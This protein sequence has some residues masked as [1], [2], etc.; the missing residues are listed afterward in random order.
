MAPAGA[1]A[2]LPSTTVNAW[3]HASATPLRETEPPA[4]HPFGTIE[5]R[6]VSARVFALGEATHG[7]HESFELKRRLT[8]HMVR[9]HGYRLVAYEASASS[10]RGGDDYIAGRTN[11]RLKAIGS[12]GMLVWAIDEN[13]ELLDDLRAWNSSHAASQRVRLI[14]VDAQDGRAVVAR[15][16]ALL[17]PASASLAQRAQVLVGRAPAATQRMYGG[18]R[19]AFDTVQTE[20]A[21]LATELRAAPLAD[22][23]DGAEREL[24]IQELVGHL[25][26]Y[27]S[28]GGRDRLMASLL[29]TQLAGVPAD[30]RCIV[31]AHN[32]HVK[33]S[34]LRYLGSDELAMG[35]HLA[36]A[37]GDGYYALGFAFGEGEFQ[38]NAL[39]PDGTWGFKRYT[40]S[41]P[42]RTS[43]EEE[44]MLA[45]L[46][47][48]V[49]DLRGAGAD[50]TLRAW[51]DTGHGQ[52][53]W[54]GYNV[55]DD[56]DAQTRDASRLMRTTPSED[57][58]GFA[59]L[60]RT[61]AA[62]PVDTSLIIARS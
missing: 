54:G 45:G 23:L 47:D 56:A 2:Q 36:H 10:V 62:T 18:E 24:R 1:L 55:P 48:F 43:L 60:A 39:R 35:G 8:M 58:D 5:S 52:R 25:G 14:G 53:W 37:L 41:A 26:M 42:P 21:L 29:L 13:G 57:F 12:L 11:D 34:T 15:L 32:A 61:R 22:P 51:L 59:F 3:L 4:A 44:F 17:A 19:A 28:N 46:G 49:V 9:E 30:V 31:W 6:M 20:A 27:G 50:P 16:R 38:A 33:K 40:M 7:Q